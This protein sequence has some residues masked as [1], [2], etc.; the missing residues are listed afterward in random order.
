MTS[1]TCFPLFLGLVF[2]AG[3][4]QAEEKPVSSNYKHFEK[5]TWAIGAW[6]PTKAKKEKPFKEWRFAWTAN[7]NALLITQMVLNNGKPEGQLDSLFGW[8]KQKEE[9]RGAGFGTDGITG[10]GWVLQVDKNKFT[11]VVGSSEWVFTLKKDNQM[12]VENPQG[13]TTNYRR[14]SK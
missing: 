2:L 1:K 8:D 9:I 14:T 11:I 5:M 13:Q 4:A 7:K 6:Q 3:Q 12:T 10:A